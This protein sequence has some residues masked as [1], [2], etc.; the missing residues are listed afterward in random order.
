NSISSTDILGCLFV[1]LLY[2]SIH[3]QRVGP[4]TVAYNGAC[5]I[6]ALSPRS[7]AWEYYALIIRCPVISAPDP[8]LGK[9]F[10]IKC[11]NVHGIGLV[12]YSST[13]KIA[14]L[15]HTTKMKLPFSSFG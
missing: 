1:V 5:T 9:S 12:F 13:I 10:F 7:A 2:V 4:M 15:Y 11:K 8:V 3:V 14:H 6:S